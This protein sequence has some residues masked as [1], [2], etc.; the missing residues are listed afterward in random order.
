M[1]MQVRI[2][3]SASVTGINLQAFQKYIIQLST[4]QEKSVLSVIKNMF[5]P[6]IQ[7]Y[8]VRNHDQSVLTVWD[9]FIA[10]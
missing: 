4:I 1:H 6:N 7:I 9:M 2:R 10:Y 8:L 3:V 5:L